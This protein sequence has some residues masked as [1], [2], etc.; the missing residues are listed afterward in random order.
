[1]LMGIVLALALAFLIAVAVIV[2]HF[3]LHFV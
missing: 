1:M 2:K 3:Q